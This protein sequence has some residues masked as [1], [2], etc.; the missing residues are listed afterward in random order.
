MIVSKQRSSLAAA[1]AVVAALAV[2]AAAHAQVPGPD[3]IQVVPTD[4]GPKVLY[5]GVGV[6][7]P[8]D[9]AVERLDGAGVISDFFG[10]GAIFHTGEIS[11]ARCSL[12]VFDGP[13]GRV[14]SI[15]L[16]C[17]GDRPELARLFE[18]FHAALSA[19]PSTG[20]PE[21]LVFGKDQMLAS[22]RLAPK[23][24]DAGWFARTFGPRALRFDV[25][26]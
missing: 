17:D 3:R 6:G 9:R 11:G 7:T 20:E 16:E 18:R 24:V 4:G 8:R 2:P 13:D 21:S 5:A 22:L 26:R 10:R 15:S 19:L 12:A 1:I 23:E 25:Y 14:R